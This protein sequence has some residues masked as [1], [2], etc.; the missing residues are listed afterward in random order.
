[1]V[2]AGTGR[3]ERKPAASLLLLGKNQKVLWSAP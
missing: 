3:K 2:V 1:L